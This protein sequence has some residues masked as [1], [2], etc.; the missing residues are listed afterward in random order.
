MGILGYKGASF[1]LCLKDSI[2]L[3]REA[4]LHCLILKN[5]AS[6]TWMIRERTNGYS[7]N[8]C[9]INE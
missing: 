7:I 6:V 2:K 4:A 5:D 8:A 1:H 3:H 9:V